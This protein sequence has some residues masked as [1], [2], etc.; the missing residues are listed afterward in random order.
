MLID[1]FMN[2]LY[3]LKRFAPIMFVSL[4]GMEILLQMGAMKKLEPLGRPL[5]RLAHLPPPTP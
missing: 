1:A 4:F 3:I 5:A 2:T